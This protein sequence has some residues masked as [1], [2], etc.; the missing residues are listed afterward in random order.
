MAK[1]KTKDPGMLRTHGPW[2]L[3]LI[4]ATVVALGPPLFSSRT[5]LS[6]ASADLAS[7]FLYAR[8]F[9]ATE[10]A[11]GNFPL[12]NPYIYGG[13]PFL[14][15]FQS[16]LLY[17]PNLIFLVLPLGLAL[18]WS[19]AFHVILL[20]VAMYCWGMGRKLHPAAACLAGCVAML[21]GTFFLHIYAGH[22]SN[23][24][25]MA[26]VPFVFLGIDGWLRRRHGGWILLAAAA[27]AMQIYAG[28]P[29][30]VY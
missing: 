30:Y 13:V 20:G 5:V 28:H 29:Q 14:G 18:N 16:A 17:V 4:V 15:D 7:Q 19:I 9:A 10:V 23:I 8:A 12:W 6:S 3:V 21:G 26:W 2:L 11:L 27:V 1:S 22:L 24:C 25:T